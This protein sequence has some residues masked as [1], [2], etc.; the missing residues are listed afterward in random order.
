MEMMERE[1]R[2]MFR[3]F[4]EEF[5][6]DTPPVLLAPESKSGGN[7]W[8]AFT[9]TTNGNG[10]GNG[11]RHTEASRAK[12][13]ASAKASWTPERR[14]KQGRLIK[15]T[16]RRMAAEKKT[17][18]RATSYN[19]KQPWGTFGWQRAHDYLATAAKDRQASI[20]DILKHGKISSSAS[21]IT[22]VTHHGDI[23]K[24]ISPGVYGLKKILER[25]TEG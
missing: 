1:V 6:S 19:D 7:D 8:P 4:P 10:N 12:I 11:H 16:M 24:R 18:N 9:A 20:A 25:T 3:M 23:F 2:E 5:A 14:A 17:T 13:S 21:F 22:G 15:K